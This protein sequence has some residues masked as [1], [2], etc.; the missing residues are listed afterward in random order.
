VTW[1]WQ[2]LIALLCVAAA[3]FVLGRRSWRLWKGT[4][5]P[6]GACASC[7]VQEG[8]KAPLAKPLV[9]LDLNS[10]GATRSSTVG[11]PLARHKGSDAH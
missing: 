2:Q 1:D 10:P 8:A 3:L 4:G 6:G 9:T 7:P 11:N 5:R